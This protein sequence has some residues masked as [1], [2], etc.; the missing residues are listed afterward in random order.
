MSPEVAPATGG[1]HPPTLASRRS[2]GPYP[3]ECRAAASGKRPP[4]FATGNSRKLVNGSSILLLVICNGRLE[5]QRRANATGLLSALTF[6]LLRT[7]RPN[8]AFEK[9]GNRA[10]NLPA[11]FEFSARTR[12]RTPSVRTARVCGTLSASP[13][14]PGSPSS[15]AV[16]RQKKMAT[17]DNAPSLLNPTKRAGSP[18]RHWAQTSVLYSHAAQCRR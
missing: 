2:G 16:Q 4:A 10:K 17:R 13:V 18:G 3:V 9:R 8:R 1:E 14:L 12:W 7:L 5:S 11:T 15:R 6:P